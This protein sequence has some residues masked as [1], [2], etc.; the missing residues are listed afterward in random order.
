[1]GDIATGGPKVQENMASNA[2]ETNA[3]LR[4]ESCFLDQFKDQS[5]EVSADSNPKDQVVRQQSLQP[6]WILM[7]GANYV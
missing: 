6:G 5:I 7:P 4:Q 2:M 1:M 3:L